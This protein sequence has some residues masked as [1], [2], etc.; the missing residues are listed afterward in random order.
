[1]H[2]AQLGDRVRVRYQRRAAEAANSPHRPEKIREF[3]VGGTEVLRA[4]SQGVLGMAPGDH[5]EITLAPGEAYGQVQ[6]KLIRAIPRDKFPPQLELRVG[7]RLRAKHLRSGRPR[8]VV[9]ME[10]R[11]D[12]VL[13]N[14]NHPMA[15]QAVTFDVNLLSL[16]TSSTANQNKPQH[17]VGGES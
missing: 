13:V 2:H 17:D 11:P 14:G 7:K 15:G 8:L 12:S 1:M 4:L 9:V 5:R 10:I 16:D 3:T 6:R